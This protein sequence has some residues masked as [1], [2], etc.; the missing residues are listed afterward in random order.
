[1]EFDKLRPGDLVKMMHGPNGSQKAVVERVSERGA[2]YVKKWSA[3]SQRFTEP[4]RIYEGEYLGY[5]GR[6]S[7][8]TPL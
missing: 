4:V 8:I 1:M 6:W 7:G 3:S 5:I 2:I